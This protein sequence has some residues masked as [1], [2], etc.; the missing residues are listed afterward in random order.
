[1]YYCSRDCSING[2]EFNDSNTE[3][4]EWL[5]SPAGRG[6]IL[7]IL[8]DPQ[9]KIILQIESALIVDVGRKKFVDAKVEAT[10]ALEGEGP[11]IFSA[12][13]ILS[14]VNASI[15]TAH[16]PNTEAIIRTITGSNS[17]AFAQAT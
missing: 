16:L 11:L 15:Y 14:A 13:K 10:Y 2:H 9:K 1:M 3:S 4:R 8:G 7:G 17:A 12:F 6:K 5:Y